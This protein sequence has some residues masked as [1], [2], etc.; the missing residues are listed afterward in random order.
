MTKSVDLLV[1]AGKAVQE[2]LDYTEAEHREF[3]RSCSGFFPPMLPTAP[4][5]TLWI[6][7]GGARSIEEL[8]ERWRTRDPARKA[9][10]S[11]TAVASMSRRALGEMIVE[12]DRTEWP[13][14]AAALEEFERR[15]QSMLDA[16]GMTTDHYFPAHILTGTEE[17]EIA[18]GAVRFIA[19]QVWLQHVETIAKKPLD[20]VKTVAKAWESKPVATVTFPT[21]LPF[22][23]QTVLETLSGCDWVAIV[24]VDGNEPGRS[25]ER[26][27]LAA[28]LAIDALG[29]QV[30]RYQANKMR[31]PGDELRTTRTGSLSQ[32]H[33]GDVSPGVI[34]DRP[35]N[36]WPRD[37]G[38]SYVAETAGFRANAGWAIDAVLKLPTDLRLPR[39]QHRWCDALFWFGEARR[40]T[41]EFMALVRYAICLDILSENGQEF[42]IAEILADMRR[43]NV[44]DAWLTDGSTLKNVVK[45]LY[46]TARSQYGHGTRPALLND[47]PL[48]RE[49]AD[50]LA[51]RAMVLYLDY[52]SRYNGPDDAK[53]FRKAIPELP[54]PV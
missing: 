25:R 34:S 27:G 50:E 31:G 39:L 19:R 49:A 1:A 29:T 46:N 18:V 9:T 35:G 3:R 14:I 40:D 44:D 48:P 10:T 11:E 20:W 13:D 36:D 33:G 53:E 43:M 32:V 22:L 54:A 47:L 45:R 37:D 4:G 52:L 17:N 16:V 30:S 24:T 6:T 2:V 26:A 38:S 41:M 28:R 8:G 5:K 7:E 51:R 15:L 12:H 21:S 23:T 42:G